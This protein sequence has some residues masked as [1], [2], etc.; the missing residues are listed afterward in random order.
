M[1]QATA[2][3]PVEPD[4]E[5]P[6]IR[7]RRLNTVEFHRLVEAGI[8]STTDRVEL[9]QG[10]LIEMA[11]IGPRHAHIVDLLVE[12]LSTTLPAA[13]RVRT[14]TPI[15][16]DDKTELQPD[17]AVIVRADYWEQPPGPQDVRLIIEV[18]D[19]SLRYDRELKMPF[20]ARHGVPEVW[21]VDLIAGA[22]EVYRQPGQETYRLSLRP[23][24]DETL[25][26]EGM[27]EASVALAELFP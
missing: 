14:Q 21:L 12:H 25:A 24:L 3:A 26:P 23:G 8:L 6:M 2:A 18:A 10:E 4:A 19:S 11:P 20:Y 5:E 9:V 15:R 7:R 22:V 1:M 16:F 27:P 17:L 13:Y